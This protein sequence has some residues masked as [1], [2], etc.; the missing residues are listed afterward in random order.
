MTQTVVDGL[1]LQGRVEDVGPSPDVALQRPGDGRAGAAAGLAVRIVEL[2][3]RF[4][5]AHV[6]AV[7]LHADAGAELLEET[8][9]GAV[10]DGAEVGENSLLRLGE[11]VRAKLAGLL[12]VVAV[13]RGLRIRKQRR[14]L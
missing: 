12:D 11:L 9:P 1:V 10:A 3:Q 13:L 14:R 8:H 6:L 2:R 4:F 7:D 5:E